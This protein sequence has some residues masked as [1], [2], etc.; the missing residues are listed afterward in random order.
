MLLMTRSYEIMRT[1]EK[2]DSPQHYSEVEFSCV[3]IREKDLVRQLSLAQSQ[4]RDLRTSNESSQA[5]LLDQSQ[6]QGQF[7]L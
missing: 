3:G 2:S 1:G 6:R 5:K 7:S 4:L